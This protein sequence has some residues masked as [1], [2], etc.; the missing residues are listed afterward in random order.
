MIDNTE[1]IKTIVLKNQEANTY[2]EVDLSFGAALKNLVL[3]GETIIS[4]HNKKPFASSI[5][6]PFPN[7][8]KNGEYKFNDELYQLEKG[9]PDIDSHNAIHG[10]VFNKNFT[11]ERQTENEIALTY[12]QQTLEKGFPFTF[13]ISVTYTLTMSVFHIEVVVVNTDSKAFPFALGWHPYFETSNLENSELAIKS[14]EK[15]L[16]DDRMIPNGKTAINWNDFET[17]NNQAFDDCFKLSSNEIQLKTP[18][19]Q[20][21]ISSSS[22]NNYLQL[23]TPEDRQ[24]MAIEPQ[25][26]PANC[27]NT[28]EGLQIL[29]P[30]DV[31]KLQWTVEL[32][33]K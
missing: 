1:H 12:S 7:R 27:F 4:K 3:Q 33:G 13:D 17:I 23:Y 28:Q 8:I 26:A 10:L 32:E 19:Y 29:Q 11:I 25:T 31:Y 18:D 14:T 6:F 20:I 2:A 16:V 9:S 15:F 21:K 22:K 30:D 24:S 5:L